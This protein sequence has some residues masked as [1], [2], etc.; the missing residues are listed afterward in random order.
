MSSTYF[1]I[2]YADH[3]GDGGT[4]RSRWLFVN[5]HHTSGSVM[6]FDDEGELIFQG[7][8]DSELE[9]A[10]VAALT[11]RGKH[12]KRRQVW[13]GDSS[14]LVTSKENAR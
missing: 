13:D 4:E 5:E 14:K 1:K 12:Y 7:H 10:L 6:I 9:D 11:H 8:E 3:Y 2:P